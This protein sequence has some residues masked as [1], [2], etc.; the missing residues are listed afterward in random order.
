MALSQGASFARSVL[1]WLI[2]SAVGWVGILFVLAGEAAAGLEKKQKAKYG[3][4]PK[5]EEWVQG[6]WAGP[7]IAMG[8][9]TDK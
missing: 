8:G 9:S 6:S 2:G 1:P 3:G 7:V 5:Y 4:T